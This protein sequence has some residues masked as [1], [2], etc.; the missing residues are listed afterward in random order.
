V[1]F[2][3]SFEI[4]LWRCVHLEDHPRLDNLRKL[5]PGRSPFSKAEEEK[6]ALVRF[7]LVSVKSLYTLNGLL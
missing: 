1:Q 4:A 3:P 2:L 5:G 7:K 6:E